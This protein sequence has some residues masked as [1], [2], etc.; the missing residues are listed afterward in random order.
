VM[1]AATLAVMLA[2]SAMLLVWAKRKGWF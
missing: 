1:L 2:I